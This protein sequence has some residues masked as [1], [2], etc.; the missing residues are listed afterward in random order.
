MNWEKS[1]LEVGQWADKEMPKL[2]EILSWA[3]QGME[4]LG[5]FPG[6]EEF[7]RKN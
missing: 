6:M 5:V 3:R 7:Q 1:A 2:P 4:I